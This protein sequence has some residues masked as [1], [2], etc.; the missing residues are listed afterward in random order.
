MT[1]RV[2]LSQTAPWNKRLGNPY[3]TR[4]AQVGD[5]MFKVDART[6]NDLWTVT[7]V[8]HDGNDLGVVRRDE[9]GRYVLDEH[10]QHIIDGYLYEP[11]ATLSWAREIIA[12]WTAPAAPQG[13]PVSVGTL[14][15]P[16]EKLIPVAALREGDRV[17]AWSDPAIILRI[18]QITETGAIW[19]DGGWDSPLRFRVLSPTDEMADRAIALHLRPTTADEPFGS[20]VPEIRKHERE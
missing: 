7:E 20:P 11:A 14:Y 3:R 19:L 5:R 16:G 1:G 15:A 17:F 4:W 12:G 6:L 9:R 13:T 10:G 2:V 8:D 18:S